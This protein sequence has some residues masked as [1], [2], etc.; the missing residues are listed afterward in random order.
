VH[1]NK[2]ASSFVFTRRIGGR[3][4]WLSTV[5]T[6]A[7]CFRLRHDLFEALHV[8]HAVWHFDIE[9][10]FVGELQEVLAIHV[11][12]A[13][14]FVEV[15]FLGSDASPTSHFHL[16]VASALRA[17]SVVVSRCGSVVLGVNLF[18]AEGLAVDP[19]RRLQRTAWG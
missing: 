10:L 11:E 17:A 12:R 8:V 7:V 13:I 1:R 6:F 3:A 16:E 19:I 18:L 4:R 2:H 14:F 9:G 15:K 5:C